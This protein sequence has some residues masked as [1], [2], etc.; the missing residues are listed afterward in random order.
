MR[1]FNVCARCGESYSKTVEPGLEFQ[2]IDGHEMFGDLEKILN[3]TEDNKMN[4][5]F[6]KVE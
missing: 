3:T 4:G 1:Y 6:I 2:S 5:P